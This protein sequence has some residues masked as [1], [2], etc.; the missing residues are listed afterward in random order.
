[1][2]V[3]VSPL[4]R[5]ARWSALFVGVTYGAVHNRTIGKRRRK[6]VA[7]NEKKAEEIAQLKAA[8]KAAEEA[9]SA[10]LSE[11]TCVTPAWLRNI[12]DSMFQTFLLQISDEYD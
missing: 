6:E 2:P 12:N 3:Q 4:I 8:Q 5:G 7:I 11:L 9:D 1:M 10:P